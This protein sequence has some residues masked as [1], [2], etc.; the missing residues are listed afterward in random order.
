LTDVINSILIPEAD[1]QWSSKDERVKLKYYQEKVSE[2]VKH[3][4]EKVPKH[5]NVGRQISQT[6]AVK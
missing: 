3:L 4:N 2:L 1:A 6:Q 5:A